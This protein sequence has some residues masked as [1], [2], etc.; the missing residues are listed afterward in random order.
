MEAENKSKK[1][2]EPWLEKYSFWKEMQGDSMSICKY[3]CDAQ[4]Q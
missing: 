2:L 4:T 1:E 3:L